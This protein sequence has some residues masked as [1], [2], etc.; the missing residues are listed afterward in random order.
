MCENHVRG[1]PWDPP[2]GG[3]FR[4][5]FDFSAFFWRAFSEG[6]FGGLPGSILS[7]FWDVLGRKFRRF[8]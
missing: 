3:H 7:G 1:S 8:V 6:G 5:F 2:L 4:Y